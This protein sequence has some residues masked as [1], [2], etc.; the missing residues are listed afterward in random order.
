MK[1]LFFFAWLISITTLSAQTLT[2]YNYSVTEG[3]PS[4]ES[5]DVFQDN[6]GFMWFSTDNGIVR[7]DGHEMK[8]YHLKD[9]LTDPVV[10]GFQQDKKGRIW[11][12][13]FSGRLSYFEKNVI[14]PYPHNDTLQAI[15][16]RNILNFVY[17]SDPEELW[18]TLR[19]IIGRIDSLGN[20]EIDTLNAPLHNQALIYKTI[21]DRDLLI[22]AFKA[23]PL[24]V[25]MI[26]DKAFR[27][28]PT[29]AEYS[30]R[31][32][33]KTFWKNKLYI[34]AFNDV[35][36]YDGEQVRVVYRAEKPIIS[37]N[38]DLEQQLWIGFLNGGVLRFQS[39]DFKEPWQPDFLE[40]RSV[41]KTL[42]SRDSSY[43]FSTLESGI[44]YLAN[45]TISN[46]ELPN[47]TIK[48]VKTGSRLIMVAD[49]AAVARLYD[50]KSRKL[51]K[52]KSFD[53]AIFST[54]ITS[55]DKI[56]ISSHSSMSLYDENL[57]MK[58]SHS[59]LIANDFFEDNTGRIWGNSPLRIY[60]FSPQG[61]LLKE[62][63]VYDVYR[64]LVVHDSNLYLA[65]RIGLHIRNK[66]MDIIGK[67][68]H[69]SNFKISKLLSLNDSIL[70]VATMGNGFHLFNTRARTVLAYDR[71]HRFIASNIYSVL[72]K[73]SLLWLGTDKGLAMTP[74]RS[75]LEGNPLFNFLS[76]ESGLVGNT[77][78]FLAAGENAVWAFSTDAFS[79]IP[80]NFTRFANKHP[81]FYVKSISVN[82][83]PYRIED[84]KSLQP[85]Q[86][87]IHID[88]GFVSFNNQNIFMRYRIQQ[89][90]TWVK[91][92]TG[93]R[94]LQFSSLAPGQ[95]SVRLEYSIDNINWKP[96][97]APII[98]MIDTPWWAKWYFYGAISLLAIALGYIYFRHQQ[99]IYNQKHHYLRIINE[100]QQK[101]LQSEVVTLER[102]RNRIA[103]ELH[104]RVG[105][106]LTA[107]KL[108]VNQLLRSQNDSDAADVEDQFQVA[109]REIKEIIYDLTPPSLERYGLFTGL[110][111]YIG[112][113][114]KR[115]PLSI[116]LKT[117]GNELFHY[118]LNIL[119]FRILQELLSNSIKHAHAKNITIHISAFDDLVNI[120]YED[121]GIGFQYDPVK[122]GLG[123]NNI[124]SRI[125]SVSGTLKFESGMYG[126]S[127]TI[128]IPLN[129]ATI[130][131]KENQNYD[132]NSTRG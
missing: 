9:G 8:N 46:Y 72:R 76:K 94:S 35:F 19:N 50:R 64:S 105:T 38:V 131:L 6:D 16:Q 110:K 31:V 85:S 124:E 51:I 122:S 52:S 53:H 103:R 24:Q 70:L 113:L 84:L 13:T 99:S 96:A 104:D 108:R 54:L 47:T 125:Q 17:L 100:H 128:D 71:E 58:K 25:V 56:W 55:T 83:E 12:R 28:T 5:Y 102:E 66:T 59:P 80:D 74:L 92:N 111:N 117:F 26:N 36:E 3:L 79:V 1:H 116:S 90:H 42:Q 119:I 18:F 67:P 115:I 95:Y 89:D 126:V 44:Y 49:K 127:Y 32:F 10:F 20:V 120:V 81:S 78:N 57:R 93:D 48:D 15:G 112:K 60:Q 130:T 68:E 30:N 123:L 132:S 21:R 63:T 11:F 27:I 97:Y 121:D 86:D 22:N 73:D 129:A 98:F 101:L 91:M 69:F 87:N 109:I 41:T 88:F 29:L 106:N 118:E 2:Y 4:V 82:G 114:D 75:L 43:W 65:E 23:A 77:I 7:F 61:E 45:A 107:I 37:L 39:P 40:G 33:C 34:T 62:D 14:K